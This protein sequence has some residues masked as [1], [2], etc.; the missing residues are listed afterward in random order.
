MRYAKRKVEKL[1]K[2]LKVEKLQLKAAKLAKMK[3]LLSSFFILT[4]IKIEFY[5]IIAFYPPIKKNL[6]ISLIYKMIYC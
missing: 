6:C 4:K 1:L 5:F 3:V 2:N